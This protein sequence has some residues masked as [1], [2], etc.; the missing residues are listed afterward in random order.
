M[1]QRELFTIITGA[2]KGLGKCLAIECAKRG[3]NLILIALP[4]ENVNRTAMDLSKKFNIKAIGYET[5]LTSNKN[6]DSMAK[7]IKLNYQIDMLINNAG[8]G[9]T[10]YIEAATENDISTIIQLN[11]RAL[12]FLTH[13]LLPV[14]KT[15]KK[16]YVLNISS[17]AAFGPMAYKT[18]YPASKAFVSS[19][20]RGLNAELKDTNISVSVA[21]P[22]GMATNPEIKERMGKYN[23]FIKSTFLS[24]G[25]TAKICIEQMLSEKTVIVPGFAN[26]ISR[27]GFKLF[28]ERLRL[29][30][31]GRSVKKEIIVKAA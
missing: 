23:S 18:V 6:V 2:S 25:E 20:S 4:F 8:V 10:N 24:P 26:K 19:F 11:M 12:V 21:H 29:N 28:P 5:D 17:L 9:G 15:Q 14:L 27:L 16:S 1:E 30:I 22:G 7:W 3:R 31:L 13:Q